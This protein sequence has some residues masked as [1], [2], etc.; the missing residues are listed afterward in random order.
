MGM[1]SSFGVTEMFQKE[2]KVMSAPRRDGHLKIVNFIVW[3]SRPHLESGFIKAFAAASPPSIP[4]AG[5]TGGP[6]RNEPELHGSCHQGPAAAPFSQ[7]AE[8]FKTQ[9]HPGAAGL[10]GALAAAVLTHPQ[11]ILM[12]SLV[13]KWWRPPLTQPVKSPAP[14][15]E[16]SWAP[17]AG[18]THMS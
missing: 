18:R 14:G 3:E 9:W 2:A 16:D 4:C 17:P 10:G 12:T 13:C 7:P 8:V 15:L 1:G 11:P 5:P 6:L